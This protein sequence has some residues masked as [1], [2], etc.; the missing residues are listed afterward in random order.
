MVLHFALVWIKVIQS[1][2]DCWTSQVLREVLLMML[3][4][5]ENVEFV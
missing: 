2:L 4:K 5:D 1:R 3:F